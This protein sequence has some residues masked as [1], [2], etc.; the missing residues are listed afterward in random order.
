MRQFLSRIL[1]RDRT[2]VGEILNGSGQFSEK[3]SSALEHYLNTSGAERGC[4]LLELPDQSPHLIHQ[5]PAELESRFPFSRTVV[6][7]VL[8]EQRGFFSFDSAEDPSTS[9]SESLNAGGSRSFVCTPIVSGTKHL[10]VIYLDNP[11]AEGVFS[12]ENLQD[13]QHFA[14]LVA[15]AIESD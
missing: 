15:N 6:D 9:D 13:L 10:G 14:E 12:E 4:V 11:P 5:G 1:G 2:S 3:I 7:I 8:D